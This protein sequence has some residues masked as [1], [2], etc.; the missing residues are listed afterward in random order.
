LFE[1]I[2]LVR[3]AEAMAEARKMN[4]SMALGFNGF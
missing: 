2:E 4:K 3:K 1:R